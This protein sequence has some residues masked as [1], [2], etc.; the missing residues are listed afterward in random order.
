M[1]DLEQRLQTHLAAKAADMSPT[2]DVERVRFGE[3]LHR[4][5]TDD[6]SRRRWTAPL[7]AAF[8]LAITGGLVVASRSRHEDPPA[9]AADVHPLQGDHVHMAYG[10]YLCDHWVELTGNQE[11]IDGDPQRYTNELFGQTGIHSHDDGVIHAHPYGPAGEGANATVGLFLQIYGVTLTDD[12][13]VFPAD[14]GDGATYDEASTTCAGQPAQL[15]ATMWP[16]ADDPSSFITVTDGLA[17]IR[18][19]NG[20]AVTIAFAPPGTQNPEP[21]SASELAELGAADAS[22]VVTDPSV[23]PFTEVPAETA[24]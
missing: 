6:P 12:R 8:V 20:A 10:L 21:L 17:A 19:T 14:Q 5:T 22:V 9:A 15:S 24:P 23:A 4:L 11:E 7:A 13:L 3:P 1:N 2:F 16:D 18:I